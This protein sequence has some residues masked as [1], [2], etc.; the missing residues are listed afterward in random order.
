[1]SAFL[2]RIAAVLAL[3]LAA[4]V[5]LLGQGRAAFTLG[6]LRRDGVLIPFASYNGRS[7]AASWPGPNASVALPIG[8]SD[9]PKAW[10]GAAGPGAPWTA[11]P[12]ENPPRPLGLVRPEQL[13]VFCGTEVG[14]KTNYA[15]GAFDPRQPTVPADGLAIA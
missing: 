9:I 1:M 8:L 13:Q 4:A 15:G 10:W 11:W 12:L 5:P 2:S 7:W 6:V 14:L 3:A